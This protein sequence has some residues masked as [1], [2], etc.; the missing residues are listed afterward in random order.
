VDS[1]S[2]KKLQNISK[3]WASSDLEGKRILHKTLF[4]DGIFYNV[5]KHQYLTREVNKFIELVS[6]V[7]HS[8][9]AKKMGTLKK[10][11]KIPTVARMGQL[12]NQ[13]LADFLQFAKL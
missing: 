3:I 9:G 5:E 4:P 12:S 2:L 6:S 11:L 1:A 8:C 7:S 10:I 13:I